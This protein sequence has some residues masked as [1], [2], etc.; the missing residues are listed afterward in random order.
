MKPIL[1]VSS[2]QKVFREQQC[3]EAHVDGSR[4]GNANEAAVSL[5]P[6]SH[7]RWAD[8]VFCGMAGGEEKRK[9]LI[10]FQWHASFLSL[11][12]TVRET[13]EIKLHGSCSADD[14]TGSLLRQDDQ[15]PADYGS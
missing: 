14:P 13:S 11:F 8:G 12:A 9:H 3:R 1:P 15:Y 6:A 4:N 5:L 2:S 10:C 7:D